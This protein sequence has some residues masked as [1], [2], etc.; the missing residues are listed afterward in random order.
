MKEIIITRTLTIPINQAFDLFSRQ[1]N[2][3]W[4]KEYTWSKDKLDR[5]TIESFVGGRCT[6]YG[7]HGFQVDWGRVLAWYPPKHLSFS[8]QISPRREPI[9]D[10]DKA[11]V[12]DIKFSKITESLTQIEL[13]HRNFLNHGKGAEDYLEALGSKYGWPLI[14]NAYENAVDL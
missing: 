14:L 10:P 7:P 12:V 6:E 3:W 11:S 5:I 2:S 4:P 9:P 13:I 1:L 8:W